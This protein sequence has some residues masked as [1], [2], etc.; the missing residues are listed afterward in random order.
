[1]ATLSARLAKIEAQVAPEIPADVR[2]P[3]LVEMT[4]HFLGEN[5]PEERIPCGISAQKF[6][7]DLMK[8]LHGKCRPL[9]VRSDEQD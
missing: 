2:D 7:R 8:D 6:M 9:P 5:F 3:E 1:M 4:K